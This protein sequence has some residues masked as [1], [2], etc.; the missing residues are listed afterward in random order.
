MRGDF[1]RLRRGAFGL[2][3]Q[4]HRQDGLREIN[5]VDVKIKSALFVGVNDLHQQLA[6]ALGQTHAY[7]FLSRLGFA[8]CFFRQYLPALDPRLAAVAAA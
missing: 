4:Q 2:L 5:S 1:L 7:R 8:L 3:N 6:L